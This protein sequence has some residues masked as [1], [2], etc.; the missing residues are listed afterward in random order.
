MLS[1]PPSNS[2]CRTTTGRL[3][4]YLVIGTLL[5]G[6][7]LAAPA[8]AEVKSLPYGAFEVV[9]EVIVP[10]SR[11]QVYDAFTKDI[12]E[13]WDHTFVE[14]PE[15]LYIE[16]VPG[17]GFWEIFDE[18]GDGA[19]HARVI[20]AD[21]GSKLR[22]SGPMGFSGNALRMVHTLVFDAADGDGT[23]L[24]VT[25]RGAGQMDAEWKEGVDRIWHHF[26]VERF[27]PY[28]ES[29]HGSTDAVAQPN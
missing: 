20:Y 16:A 14:N 2:S 10:G 19:L 4:G 3:A 13:W 26:L 29:L 8:S 11:E 23:R 28:V 27:K 24:H 18:E 15:R 12:G 9:H 25:V 17:G 21:R 5:S 1:N 7:C 6:L 22:F